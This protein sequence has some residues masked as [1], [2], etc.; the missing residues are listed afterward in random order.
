MASE[1]AMAEHTKEEELL[2]KTQEDPTAGI[3]LLSREER[4]RNIV[5]LTVSAFFVS[6]V[7]GIHFIF[8]SLYFLEIN[9]SEKLFGIVGTIA[10]FVAILG[11]I[12]ADFLNG[13]LGYKRAWILGQIL[14]A[15]AFTVFIFTPTKITWVVIAVLLISLAMSINES[16]IN[17]ILTETAGEKKKG[18]IT[19]LISFFGLFGEVLVATTIFILTFIVGIIYTNHERSHYYLYGAIIYMLVA[20]GILATITDPSKKLLKKREEKGEMVIIKEEENKEELFKENIKP[21]L[22][23]KRKTWSFFKGFID[24][25]RDKWVL[26]VAFAFFMDALL[27]SIAFGVHWA[28]L[29][30]ENLLGGFAFSDKDISLL[31]MVSSLT[32]LLFMYFGRYIDKLGA[33]F[34]LFISQLCGLGWVILTICFVFFPWL[35]WIMI[36]ARVLLGI[37]IALWIPS[38]I[39]LFTNVNRERKS[40]VYNAI[41][42]FRSIGW[43]PGGFIAGLLYDAI[44]QPYG[45]LTPM[46]ILIGGMVILLPLFFTLPNRPDE[47]RTRTLRKKKQDNSKEQ[48]QAK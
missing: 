22:E 32:V 20:I 6:S 33:R 10:S 24:A 26:R 36:I 28:G 11:L 37:S 41:A 13:F 39:A 7:N 34:F 5:F 15:A 27:W 1:S 45:Y 42:I 35:Y 19:T 3:Q 16:P 12:F 47:L 4:K 8:Y 14:M 46:F 29:Q 43:L 30:D 17:I 31:T 25:F 44:P 9:D 23:Q 40:K 18:A 48:S 21:E 38:T 2:R